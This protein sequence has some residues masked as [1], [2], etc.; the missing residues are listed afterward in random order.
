MFDKFFNS[1]TKQP[2]KLCYQTTLKE[3]DGLRSKLIKAVSEILPTHYVSE[4]TLQSRLE[5]LGSSK[6]L[7]LLIQQLPE[8]KISRS[9]ELGEILATEYVNDELEYEIPIKKLR[10]KDSREQSLRGDDLIG[11]IDKE[12]SLKF[13]KGEVKSRE[14]ITLSV[15]KELEE[16][17]E[18]DQGRPDRH[19]LL[20]I[21]E[22]LREL[23]NTSLADK[24]EGILAKESIK[25]EDI[26]HLGF[27]FSGNC[28]KQ[29]HL[30][31]LEEY[32][33]KFK[34]I[35][36]GL[37]IEDHQNF[38]KT[39]YQ[40]AV[41]EKSIRQIVNRETKDKEKSLSLEELIKPEFRGRLL[42]RGL[43]R[44]MIWKDGHVPKDGPNFSTELTED[45]LDYG[46]ALFS[47]ALQKLESE[48]N[49]ALLE[50][51]FLIAGESI[52]SVVKKG[53]PL[54]SY[55]GYHTLASAIAFHLAGYSARSYCMIPKDFET[56]L[57][58]S[59]IEHSLI[60]L[61]RRDLY[62][63]RNWVKKI[64]Y[65]DISVKINNESLNDDLIQQLAIEKNF[66]SAMAYLEFA[67][68]TGDSLLI[69]KTI[70]KL[71]NGISVAKDF[72]HVPMW[73]ENFM[74]KS[75]V[76][77]LWEH[78]LYK[79]MPEDKE[80]NWNQLR[81]LFISSLY[82][83]EKSEIDLWPSQLEAGKRCFNEKDDL[84]VT[85][86]TSA[87]KTRIAE[88]CILR[89][90]S[91]NKRIIYITPLRALSAQ[92]E[93]TLSETFVPLDFTVSSLYGAI[94]STGIDVDTLNNQDIVVSTPEK[95]SFALKNDPQ[96]LDDVGLVIFD[97]GHTIGLG[98]R[99]INYEILIQK[100]LKRKD[101]D[102][103]RLVCL[104]AMFPQGEKLNEY[105]N[106]I[107]QDSPG[108]P[109][110]S[111]W[112]PTRQRFGIV[113]WKSTYARLDFTIGSEKPFIPK[114]IEGKP[115]QSRRRNSFPQDKNEL[116]LASAWKQVSEGY[117][118]LIYC[119]IKR[120]VKSLA[121]LALKL[122]TQGYMTSLVDT[123]SEQSQKLID[124]AIKL[125]NEWLG[126][127]HIAI[128]CLKLGIAVHHAGLP[129]PFLQSVE[130]LI[131]EN[132]CKVI[133]S[134]PTLAQGLNLSA[135]C[136][137]VHSIYRNQE[138]V[139]KK[140][141]LNVIGRVGRA[142]VDI[143]G[144][145]LFPVHESDSQEKE[146]KIIEWNK[147][148]KSSQVENI[149]SGFFLLVEKLVN[150][151]SNS[152]GYD[153][154]KMLE[155]LLSN[156][157]IE[158][159]KTP[160]K[161]D[162]IL[163]EDIKRWP[164][165]LSYL[166]VAILS[167]A[168]NLEADFDQ[169]PQILDEILKGSLWQRQMN[170]ISEKN[171]KLHQEI[172]K[173]RTSWIWSN[174]NAKQRKGFFSAGVGVECG[175]YI[176]EHKEMI[177]NLLYA[178]Q[179]IKGIHIEEIKKEFFKAIVNFADLAFKQASFK[180]YKFCKC[181]QDVLKEWLLG[182]SA[183]EIIQLGGKETVPFIQDALIYKLVWAIEAVFNQSKY[184]KKLKD[185]LPEVQDIYNDRDLTDIEF[186]VTSLALE[187]GTLNL[188]E[189]ILIKSGL[190]SRL[191]AREAVKK[192]QGKFEDYNSM[193]E[194]LSKLP[195]DENWPT[196]ETAKEWKKFIDR[197]SEKKKK[198]EIKTW[199]ASC[200]W[201]DQLDE[202]PQIGTKLRIKVSG[203][204]LFVLSPD[205]KSLGNV[206]GN[207]NDVSDSANIWATVIS[208]ND[209]E[210]TCIE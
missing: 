73:W 37:H 105:T 68:K 159:W 26:K 65:E 133:I 18:K 197:N 184:T 3:K 55:R 60:Y 97:E 30:K 181:W 123:S 72:S 127:D 154:D 81:Q 41:T 108:D 144:I 170:L 25:Q 110:Q 178:E 8:K 66:L 165:Y 61:L 190:N 109:I 156:Q 142:F 186:K 100:I 141:F 71:N 15:I 207:Q 167:L 86:P 153:K 210:I 57:N 107:R 106:W 20:F 28:P 88:M 182:S 1:S 204:E 194:W 161:P 93:R 174:T 40:E 42:A 83:R 172:I 168:D 7:K 49:K 95:L 98:E 191:T 10:H 82:M 196:P 116:V 35:L 179:Y 29:I 145:V 177:R 203:K 206:I 119:P 101:S 138:L 76:K 199:T 125:G 171:Q 53:I 27:T 113:E 205:F 135:S 164:E 166:D 19:S 46:Y 195:R 134:S 121:E 162:N 87:G 193:M 157:G 131:R 139:P 75:L 140:E 99:E 96:I 175:K 201:S 21:A 117:R 173:Q 13:L 80:A 137:I 200:N 58:I 90:L 192:G 160:T 59:H 189:C 17:L 47:I 102:H 122:K 183:S 149:R 14:R 128:K 78:T 163:E 12:N 70:L 50:K 146:K 77:D 126:E 69:D 104:S 2:K 31:N 67:L 112:K 32:N 34:R 111:D 64:I 5:K 136:L 132:I 155:Y 114:F 158:I 129:R 54:D 23:N 103:R 48:A 115:P 43:A 51:T 152:K 24:I 208:K 150:L 52:E 44:G 92:T 185:I 39:V 9:G 169:L 62:N 130:H 180:P 120:S 56:S 118:V 84:V 4:K 202:I 148:I 6:S 22:R 45:L 124:D 33:G 16:Q 147:L 11:F 38:I 198:L 74:A 188:S 36:V 94:G 89:S 63:F 209:L 176:D 91:L 79:V 187:C 143:D 85:L 151:I